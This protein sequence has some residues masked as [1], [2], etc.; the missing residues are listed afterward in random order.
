MMA[1]KLSN[2]DLPKCEK[3]G[4]NGSPPLG[5]LI[6]RRESH[7]PI[8]FSYAPNAAIVRACISHASRTVIVNKN[9][10]LWPSKYDNFGV[11]F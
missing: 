5:T 8:Y 10:A 2:E 1:V 11:E 3:T 4:R 7:S 9:Q 6:N